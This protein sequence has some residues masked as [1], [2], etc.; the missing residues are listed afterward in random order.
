[1]QQRAYGAIFDMD[2]VLVDSSEAHYAAWKRLGEQ[3]GVPFERRLF[4]ETF[5][6]TN[7]QIIPKWLGPKAAQADIPGL[8]VHK[9]EMYREVARSVLKPLDG[10]PELLE[11]LWAA[12]FRMAVGSSGPKANV[13]MVLE[14]LGAADKF[15]AMAT[16]EEVTQGKPDPQVFLIA[17]RK[18]GLPPSRCVVLEDAPQGVQAGL[19]AGAKVLAVTSTRPAHA[20]HGAHRIVHSLREVDAR[21]LEALVDQ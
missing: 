18:L 17:A 9:E 10:V 19:A 20:L 14:I 8:S 1:V 4:D 16:L 3:V 21:K 2:G 13:E 6:M 12:G 7:F 5:G 15:T 11:S